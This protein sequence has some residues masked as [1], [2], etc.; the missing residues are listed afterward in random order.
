M[1]RMK[2]PHLW[3]L[4]LII[5]LGMGVANV[6]AQMPYTLLMP[7]IYAPTMGHLIIA[8]AHIDSALTGEADEAI[9]LWNASRVPIDLSQWTIEVNGRKA[10]FPASQA[11]RLQPGERIWC[12]NEAASFRMTFGHFPGCEWG[13]DSNPDVLDLDG[14]MLQL[15]NA[16]GIVYLRD[17]QG[18]IVDTLLYGDRAGPAVGWQGAPVQIYAR[19]ALGKQGQVWQRKIL[20]DSGIPVDDDQASDW[21]SDLADVAWGRRVRFPGWGGWSAEDGALPTT[22]TAQTS[23]TVAIAPEG[24]YTPIANLVAN[25]TQTLDLSLYTFEHPELAQHIADAAQRGVKVRLLLEG[26]PPGGITDFQRWCVRLMAQAGVDVRYLATQENAPRGLQ[27]RYRYTHAKYGIADGQR[28]LIGTE[29]FS[30]DAMPVP[31]QHAPNVG[32]RRGAYLFVESPVVAEAFAQLFATDWSPDRFFD[33]QP[34]LPT[35]AQYGDPAPEFVFPPQ[36][37]YTVQASP[38]SQPVNGEGEMQF[39][40]MTAPENVL[41]PN[42]GINALIQQA[43]AGDELY[44]VQLYEH[45]YWGDGDS[46]PIADPNPRLQLLVD[47]ARR[48]T[49]VRILLDSFFDEPEALRS[50]RATVDYLAALSAAEGLDIIGAVGNPTGGGIHAK[51][52]MANVGGERWAAVG[53]LNG[54]EVSHKINREVMLLVNQP[55]V[56]DRLLEVF[57]HDWTLN[58]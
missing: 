1:P 54:G 22:L 29:N 10:N 47:A 20:A 45:K 18:Q 15:N 51:W 35:H 14:A 24:L 4:L 57:W 6:R 43:G 27:P 41:Y 37:I 13:I 56:Y 36:P 23:I 26:G 32:G 17:A 25:A 21:A 7:A 46:N 44:L 3:L 58:E 2:R 38:F 31:N 28:I 40:L 33:L 55:L 8:A 11:P 16:G 52:F 50:N 34:Y 53:S 9:L 42:A 30:W 48:G 19:G 5:G 49:K 12:A 39:Q